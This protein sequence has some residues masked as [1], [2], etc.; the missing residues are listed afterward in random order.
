[1]SAFLQSGRIYPGETQIFKVRFRPQAVIAE[2]LAVEA[3]PDQHGK[4]AEP[5][6]HAAKCEPNGHCLAYFV[7]SVHEE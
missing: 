3:I 4:P 7:L 5:S 1:M 6:D 2:S